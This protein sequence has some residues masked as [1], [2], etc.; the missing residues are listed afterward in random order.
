[1]AASSLQIAYYDSTQSAWITL[2]TTSVDTTN[3]FIYTQIT[4]FTPYAVTYGVKAVTPAPT[5]TTTTPTTSTPVVTTTQ[6]SSTTTTP[7]PLVTTTP[8]VTPLPA[9][10]EAS[11]L[12][13][14]P[15]TVKPGAKVNVYLRITNTGDVTGTDTVVLKINN[16][17]VDSQNVTLAGGVSTVVTFTTS[18]Q[19]T[20]KY[21]VGVAGL[22]GNF[23][24]SKSATPGWFWLIAVGAF[25]VGIILAVGF[26]LL[27]KNKT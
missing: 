21:A 18:S 1:V 12:I 6:P 27:R 15:S 17:V 25:V 2:T 9:A 22:N 5:T 23:I 20:G 8:V 7:P 16:V 26:V 13:I 14:N 10:F 19:L 24:V 11:S 3:H 4:H